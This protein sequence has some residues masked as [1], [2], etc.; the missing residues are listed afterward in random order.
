MSEDT[1]VLEG[2]W[3]TFVATG[4]VGDGLERVQGRLIRAVYRGHLPSGPVHIKT[5]TFPR[6]KDRLRYAFRALPA[7]HEANMLRAV[8]AAG[9]PCPEVLAVRGQR[10]WGLP[11]RCMLVLRTLPLSDE[12]EH[13]LQRGDDEVELAVRLLHA[14]IYHRD[15]HRENFVRR[16]SGELAVL[17][18]QS[19]SCIGSVR[20]RSQKVRLAVAIRLLRD[21]TPK[22]RDR[23]LIRMRDLNLLVNDTEA[24]S[25]VARAT[26]EEQQYVDRRIRRCLMSSTE[27]ERRVHLTGIEYR[28]RGTLPAGRWWCG[29]GKL[30]DAWIGQRRR[31]F[32]GGPTPVFAAFFQKW[33][34]LGGGAAL[35]VPLTCAD[36]RIEV[37]VQTASSAVTGQASG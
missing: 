7:T 14:G 3:R 22:E 4:T 12:P 30:K 20:A 33:W 10:R 23:A 19:A 15:L 37:E 1:G 35:Y 24:A 31:W 32:T 36:E 8:G 21:R 25:V 27:F 34:W 29:S 16:S 2:W 9:L 11:H 6:A 26:Q 17:D 13:A 5:M 18:L 28:A